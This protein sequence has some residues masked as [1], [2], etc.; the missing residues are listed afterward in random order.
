MNDRLSAPCEVAIEITGRCNLNCKYCFNGCSQ[1]N[2]SSAKIKEILDQVDEMNVFV[3]RDELASLTG[4]DPSKS[5]EIAVTLEYSGLTDQVTEEI[6]TMFPELNVLSWKKLQ[7]MLIAMQSMMD[8]FGFMLLIIIL[9]AMAFGIINTMLMAILER[10]HE[11]GM[12]MAVG[13]NRRRV[14][15]MIMLETRNVW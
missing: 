15:F 3:E 11:L 13:M 1:Q 12:L 8:Q 6:E 2:I 10:T 14:F 4:F 9:I 7:P 5:T